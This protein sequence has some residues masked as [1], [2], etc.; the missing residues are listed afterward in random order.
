MATRDYPDDKPLWQ[1]YIN[2]TE[3]FDQKSLGSVFSLVLE[4]QDNSIEN[5]V[6]AVNWTIRKEGVG[7]NRFKPIHSLLRRAIARHPASAELHVILL[8]QILTDSQMTD[9]ERIRQAQECFEQGMG[10]MDTDEESLQFSLAMLAAAEAAGFT[11]T[12]FTSDILRAM[13]ELFKDLPVYWHSVAQR[14]ID[15]K[16]GS[17]LGATECAACIQVSRCDWMFYPIYI[18]VYVKW[19]LWVCVYNCIVMCHLHN[20]NNLEVHLNLKLDTNN[21]I[22]RERDNAYQYFVYC[23][24][25]IQIIIQTVLHLLSEFYSQTILSELSLS[26]LNI[27]FEI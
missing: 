21:S 9:R 5:W 26:K 25:I 16:S 15:G 4:H 23:Q 7:P 22:K 18:F 13:K 6:L 14:P 24:T 17:H 2:F 8:G 19:F 20:L 12:S 27:H 11:N 10:E 1:N 3:E